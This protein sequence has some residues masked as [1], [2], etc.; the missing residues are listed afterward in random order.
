[1]KHFGL[2]RKLIP[3]TGLAFIIVLLSSSFI[4]TKA[5]PVV[6]LDNW[7]NRETHAKTGK[8]FHYLWT[9]SADSGYSRWGSIFRQKGASLATLNKPDK[10]TLKG[11]DIYMIVDPDS[12]IET[13][14]PNFIQ[15]EDIKAIERWVKK[16]GVLVLLSNDG[17]HCALEHLNYLAVRFGMIFNNVMLHPVLS[18]QYEMGAYTKFPDHPVFEGV[19]KI[20]MKEV[21][22]IS[23]MGDAKPILS[24]NGQV[25]MAETAFGKGHVVAIG[26]PWIYN[27][28]I[29]ND[30][31]PEGFENRKA[32]ENLTG[33]LLSKARK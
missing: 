18:N 32:A 24:D 23:L 16:G 14:N 22:S 8:P 10:Q 19:K 4:T 21:A 33:Y 28:Y 6:G 12:V 15:P 1:M 5:Q 7:F 25:V 11:I 17:K 9:D 27:E 30:R 29:D 3:A 13:P 26:D 20:F 2:F 31:L